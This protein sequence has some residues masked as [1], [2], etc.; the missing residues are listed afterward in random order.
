M[1]NRV[2]MRKAE[3]LLQATT[4]CTM[5]G[6]CGGSGIL[7]F[8]LPVTKVSPP[9]LIPWKLWRILHFSMIQALSIIVVVCTAD[10]CR[11]VRRSG[12]RGKQEKMKILRTIKGMG[13][14]V[15]LAALS[16]N[17][18]GVVQDAHHFDSMGAIGIACCFT[19][20]GNR[21]RC[22]MILP[23]IHDQTYQRNNT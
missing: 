23:F 9:T 8:L 3:Q 22:F 7:L 14:K 11:Y 20:G 16:N 1:A 2:T 10:N 13:L 12:H 15:E 18:F 21:D 5:P 6:M 17:G 4:R 19:C